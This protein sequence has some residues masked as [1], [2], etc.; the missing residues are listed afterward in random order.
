MKRYIFACRMRPNQQ[1][2]GTNGHVSHK[3]QTRKLDDTVM[4]AFTLFL[5]HA[6]CYFLSNHKNLFML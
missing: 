6:F 4:S 1:R 5:L 3:P 2:Q